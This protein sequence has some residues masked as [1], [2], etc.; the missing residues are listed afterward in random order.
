MM[1]Q[2]SLWPPNTQCAIALTFDLDAESV[3]IADDPANADRPVALS[4][5]R[6]GP[7]VAVPLILHMLQEMELPATFFIPGKVAEDHRQTVQA[8][9]EAGHE[10]AVH[11]YT[12][13]SPADLSPAEEEQSLIRARTI[14][15]E[16]SDEVV[17]YRSPAWELSPHTL[18]ILKKLDF[19][20]SSNMMD[21]LRPYKHAD[22]PVIE[23]PV[24]WAL[25]DAAHFWF[26][27]N[28]WNKKI[29]TPSE[30]REIWEGEF[31]ESMNSVAYLCSPCTRR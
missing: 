6:Y 31:E 19:A 5:G 11:G 13:V 3:W 16:F 27:A 23:L 29:S 9:A 2:P 30:V 12:H 14:L 8:I 15:L 20:Y 18:N 28:S 17:G 21:D 26:D 1:N 24:H 25:D 7:R 22:S 4:Q 10:L